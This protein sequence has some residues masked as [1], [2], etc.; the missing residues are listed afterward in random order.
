MRIAIFSD[1][2]LPN[3]NGVTFSIINE[4]KALEN[5]HD[6]LLFVPKTQKQALGFKIDCPTYEITGFDLPTYPG[7]R[8]SLPCSR[9]LKKAIKQHQ[10][11]FLHIQS[12]FSLGYYGLLAKKLLRVPSVA[13]FHTWLSEY[14]GHLTGGFKEELVKE[15]LEKPTWKYTRWF[16]GLNEV[17]ITPSRMLEREMKRWGIKKAS[18]VPNSISPVFFQQKNRKEQVVAFKKK[19]SIPLDKTVLLYVGR[20]SFEKR[21]ETLLEAYKSLENTNYGKKL[22]LVV[23]GDG[24]HLDH[25]KKLAVSLGLKNYV[26]TGYWAHQNLPVVYAAG[27]I[28][29]APSDTETQGLTYIEAMASGVLVIGTKAGGVVDYIKHGHSGLLVKERNPVEFEKMIAFALE[30]EAEMAVI[31][32]NAAKIAENYSYKGFRRNMNA[33]F[34]RALDTFVEST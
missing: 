31:K 19:F 15:L 9:K 26:F 18:A 11:D 27:D 34:K 8:I 6:F 7:Y 33:V 5:Q 24:P 1:T 23:V 28:F 14:V 30:N 17:V 20:I 22:F 32:R 25:Y 21:L 2:W 3:I 13:T 4:I 16:Y 12:P 10:I 29:A